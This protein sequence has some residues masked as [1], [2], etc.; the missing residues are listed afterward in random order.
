MSSFSDQL[1]QA[2]GLR[3]RHLSYKTGKYQLPSFLAPNPQPSSKFCMSPAPLFPRAG[4][5]SLEFFQRRRTR[6]PFP[7]ENIPWE[8]WTVRVEVSSSHRLARN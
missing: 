8:V 7:P 1:K 5:I 6:W 4:Q 2:T 3:Y